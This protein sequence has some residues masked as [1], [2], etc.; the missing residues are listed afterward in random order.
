MTELPK[1]KRIALL[2]ATGSIGDSALSVVASFP[3][4][5]R[6]VTMAAGRNLEKLLPLIAAFRPLVVSV[7]EEAPENGPLVKIPAHFSI[8]R[9]RFVETRTM[10][11]LAEGP[12]ISNWKVK[13]V[14]LRV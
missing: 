6:I 10:A 11:L 9:A 2:G 14:P 5:F 12:T 7:K 13:L 8:G 1:V 3:E 4:R